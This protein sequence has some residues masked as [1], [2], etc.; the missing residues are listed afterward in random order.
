D[1]EEP[2]LLGEPVTAGEALLGALPFGAVL[3]NQGEVVFAAQEHD[4]QTGLVD[5]VV[6][7]FD[8][9]D[10]LVGDLLA[11][12]GAGFDRLSMSKAPGGYWLV[13]DYSDET[14]WPHQ[15]QYLHVGEN[16]DAISEMQRIGGRGG[17]DRDHILRVLGGQG[18]PIVFFQ[19]SCEDREHRHVYIRDMSVCPDGLETAQ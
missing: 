9:S 11:G 5:L 17:R 2:A 10:Q 6:S 15:F 18:A 14:G 12:T 13:F 3:T 4:E 16:L 8:R 7:R 1:L 19:R